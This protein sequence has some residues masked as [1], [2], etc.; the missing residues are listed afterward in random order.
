MTKQPRFVSSPSQES[1]RDDAMRDLTREMQKSGASA[2]CP[3][4]SRLA[5]LAEGRLLQS[6][7]QSLHL[8]LAECEACLETYSLLCSL[9]QDTASG[10]RRSWT[11]LALAASLVLVVIS[12]LLIGPHG[13]DLAPR[14]EP[15]SGNARFNNA[16]STAPDDKQDIDEVAEEASAPLR[17]DPKSTVSPLSRKKAASAGRFTPEPEPALRQAETP[18]KSAKGRVERQSR[19]EQKHGIST[20]DTQSRRLETARESPTLI[21]PGDAR[22]CAENIR[23]EIRPHN[24]PPGRIAVILAINTQG[25]VTGITVSPP[26]SPLAPIVRRALQAHSFPAASS[27]LRH[28]RLDIEWNG[29]SWKIQPSMPSNPGESGNGGSN[30]F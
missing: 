18:E 14:T 5:A 9:L 28:L 8:H 20:A 21:A 7:R 11:P 16:E 23:I 15:T 29:D 13:R 12:V 30:S 6:D 26:E 1:S 19:L 25:M 4:E 3:D 24:I 17:A 27:P 22:A 10:S 2:Q